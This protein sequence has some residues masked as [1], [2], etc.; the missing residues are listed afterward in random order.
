MTALAR[1]GT[2]ALRSTAAWFERVGDHRAVVGS[3][4]PLPLSDLGEIARDAGFRRVTARPLAP[5]PQTLVV[6]ST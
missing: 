1:F 2:F 6:L 5:T 3:Y 4:C